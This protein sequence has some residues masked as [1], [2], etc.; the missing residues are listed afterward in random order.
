LSPAT[1]KR[2]TQAERREEAES[3]LIETAIR[4]VA[5]KGYDG[6]TLAEVAE[7]AGYSRGLP[8]HYFGRKEELLAL[9]AQHIVDTYHD[10]VARLPQGERGLPRIGTLVRQYTRGGG[11][12]AYR[13]LGILIA[14]AIIRPGLR[15]TILILNARGIENLESEIRAGVEL[16]NIRPDVDAPHQA[17]LIYAF[18]RGQM[19]FDALDPHFGSREVAEEFIATLESRIGGK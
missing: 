15:R 6:F 1:A 8:T 10:A 7:A 5:E 12:K 18:L 3:R 2:R 19:S 16:G 14:E 11:S 13:A 17:R 4:L 9:V